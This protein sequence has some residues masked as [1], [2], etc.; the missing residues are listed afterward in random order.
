[1]KKVLFLCT[2]NSCRSQMAEG[3]ARKEIKD[4]LF[5]S[6]GTNPE[7]VNPRAIYALKSI[8]IDISKYISKKVN[9]KDIDKYDLIVTLCGDVKDNCP[10][11][12]PPEKH[13]HWDVED[14]AKLKGEDNQVNLKFS[15][16]RDIIYKNI[17]NLKERL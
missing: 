11:I 5:E 8:D 3:I 2:G 9:L 7:P 4:V 13:V 15:E 16:T 6:A 17:K 10:I 1:M 14:P 12:S